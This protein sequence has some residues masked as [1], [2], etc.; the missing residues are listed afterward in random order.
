MR[1]T[2]IFSYRLLASYPINAQGPAST[3]YDYY[4]PDVS[5]ISRPQAMVVNE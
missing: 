5:P 2:L 3:A 4:N 1:G